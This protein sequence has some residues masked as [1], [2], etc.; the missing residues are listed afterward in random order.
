MRLSTAVERFDETDW[1]DPARYAQ[2]GEA[3]R[4]HWAWLWLMRSPGYDRMVRRK[5]ASIRWRKGGAV[6]RLLAG[7]LPSL[8]PAGYLFIRA[9]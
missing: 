7:D 3:D 4:R 2:L 9:A 8:F 5:A 1:E 6:H